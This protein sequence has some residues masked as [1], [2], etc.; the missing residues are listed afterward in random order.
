MRISLSL[1][2]ALTVVGCTA[3]SPGGVGDVGMAEVPQVLARVTFFPQQVSSPGRIGMQAQFSGR[4]TLAGGCLG[5]GDGD[6]AVTI[7]WHPEAE[8]SPDRRGVLDRSSRLRAQ[9]GQTVTL[10]GGRLRAG[11]LTPSLLKV[12]LPSSCSPEIILV[13][14]GIDRVE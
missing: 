2:S 14:S 5:F 11:E 9:I 10:S 13:G 12:P 6:N 1:V 8:L 4:L 3:A 7:V